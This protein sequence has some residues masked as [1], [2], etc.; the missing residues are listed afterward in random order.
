MPVP[1]QQCAVLCI[2]YNIYYRN[3]IQIEACKNYCFERNFDAKFPSENEIFND[4]ILISGT[5]VYG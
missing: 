4:A 2:R 5:F 3:V 1:V